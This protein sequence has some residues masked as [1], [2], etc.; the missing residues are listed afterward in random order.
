MTPNDIMLNSEISALF[1]HYQRS[2]LLQQMETN[3]EAHRQILRRELETLE[4]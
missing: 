2:F 4:H 1:S 3:T